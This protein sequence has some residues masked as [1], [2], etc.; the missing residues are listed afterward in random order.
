M[1][2]QTRQRIAEECGII[3]DVGKKVKCVSIYSQRRGEVAEIVGWGMGLKD[4][5]PMYLIRFENGECE[6][7]PAGLYFCCSGYTFV[8]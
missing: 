7:I 1:T 6:Y 2:K 3:K 8:E 5:R 4:G